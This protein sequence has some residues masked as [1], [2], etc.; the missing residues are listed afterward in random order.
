MLFSPSRLLE[1]LNGM[2][3]ADRYLVAYSGGRDSHVLLHALAALGKELPGRI[4]ALHVDHGLQS[5]SRDWSAHCVQICRELDVPCQVLPL[6]LR[7]E[8][9]A[10]V[11]ELAREARYRALV[12]RM[13]PG[14][15]LLTAH[16]L[17]DQSETVLLQL[18]RGAGLGGL[19]AMPPVSGYGPGYRARPLLGFSCNA[20]K[21]YALEQKLDWV[22]DPSNQN[23]RF[24]RNFLRHE[25][26]P[27]MAN[28]WPAMATTIAR[29]ARHC[30][31]AQ[32][33]VDTLC[34][35]DL[36]EISS[37]RTGRLSL[38]GLQ[39]LSLPRARAVL[40]AWIRQRGYR[41]PDTAR[42]HRAL[43]EMTFAARD[44]N[45]MVNWQ[46]A[47]LRRYRDWLY[48]IDPLV[49]LDEGLELDWDL[50]QPLS[51]PG[52]LGILRM[53]TPPSHFSGD[54]L[55]QGKVRFRHRGE[56]VRPMGWKHSQSFKKFYQQR[57]VP[58]WERQR[59]PLLY[60]NSELAAVADLCIC[61]SPSGHWSAAD[62]KLAWDRLPG[63]G[64]GAGS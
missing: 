15:M 20:L 12:A 63:S 35:R 1:V 3:E 64:M 18:L 52:G 22:E 30:A 25:I 5:A 49:P 43:R 34:Q 47:E 48:I 50:E 31:E 9:G 13:D 62:M 14:D 23:T 37:K 41:L 53:H 2:P 38:S 29:S 32:A 56:R 7:L 16:H 57:G 19:A 42:L 55:N 59:I 6:T 54:K 21:F 26:I 28:R 40:R 4:E 46:G 58:P 24:D 10:S 44:R 45:P 33:L 11:E 17:E 51:L 8:K 61:E 36:E 39:A 27:L 60:L